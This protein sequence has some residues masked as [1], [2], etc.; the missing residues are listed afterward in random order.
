MTA[1]AMPMT[2]RILATLFDMRL[3]LSFSEADCALIAALIC[4][5]VSEVA[6]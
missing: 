3:P 6:P 5:A 1:Q 4:E 2:D